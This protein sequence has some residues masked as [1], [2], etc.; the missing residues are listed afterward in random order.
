[1]TGFVD[2]VREAGKTSMGDVIIAYPLQGMPHY[3]ELIARITETPEATAA[4]PIIDA[5]GLLRMPYNNTRVVQVWGIEPESFDAVTDF[6][7]SLFWKP[8]D[9]AI[10]LQSLRNITIELWER[11][12][13]LDEELE[14]AAAVSNDPMRCV[15]WLLSPDSTR[16]RVLE[17]PESEMRKQLPTLMVSQQERVDGW[18]QL[19]MREPNLR[20]DLDRTLNDGLAL[21]E[22][23]SENDAIVL[24]I[25]VSEANQRRS[26]GTYRIIADYWM[27]NRDVTLTLL[28]ITNGNVSDPQSRVFE[29][30]NEVRFGVYQIDEQRVLIPLEV[31][32]NMLDMEEAVEVVDPDAIDEYGTPLT[33]ETIPARVTHIF[34]RATEGTTAA[35]LKERIIA[36]YDAMQLEQI[37][38]D[39]SHPLPD[40][41][42][43]VTINTWEEQQA[44]FIAPVEKERNLMRIL[45]S[46]IYFVCAGLVLVIFWAIVYEKTR[47]IGILRAV[48]ASRSG[49]LYI[50]IR[51]GLIV[52][53]LGSIVGLLLA[54]IVIRNINTIHNLLGEKFPFWAWGSVMLLAVICLAMTIRMVIRDALLPIVC[55]SLLTLIVAAIGIA[56]MLHQGFLVW[57]PKVYYFTEI[58]NTVDMFSAV[59]TMIGAVVFSVIGALI[60]AARAADI[61]PVSALRYE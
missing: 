58:P 36:V 1:M 37:R 32:Q 46:I 61:D 47:D 55:F 14:A 18:R 60:P 19:V 45:F 54:F 50:F 34:I 59:T 44:A 16:Q 23:I 2:M 13:F 26:D 5:Y 52:G 30:A 22:T 43:L 39:E 27:P 48:G 6:G 35:G 9:D 3:E 21:K 25:H 53:I 51:Y 24:G 49:I 57:D 20:S 56:M 33:G 12:L 31:A 28:P 11:K 8:V 4:S 10:W 38:S 40:R 29:V 15:L 42:L 17:L 7:N 41:E